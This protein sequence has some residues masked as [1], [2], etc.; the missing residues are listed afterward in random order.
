VV[1]PPKCCPEVHDYEDPAWSVSAVW[2]TCNSRH[3]EWRCHCGAAVYAPQP[4]PHCPSAIAARCR[5]IK[6]SNA[7][8]RLT[9]WG[10]YAIGAVE[11]AAAT[12]AAVGWLSLKFLL[13]V[14]YCQK[15]PIG[16]A[17]SLTGL[18]VL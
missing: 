2:R 8:E 15:S 14:D 3:M 12:R 4:G 16:R 6:T 1:V 17:R 18:T 11:I 7:A 5:R 9:G 10:G 13:P